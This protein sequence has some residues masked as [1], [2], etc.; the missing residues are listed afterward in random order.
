[1]QL[2]QVPGRLFEW[3]HENQLVED[4][5]GGAFGGVG[6]GGGPHIGRG[7]R[8]GGAAF[9]GGR[10]ALTTG[11]GGFSGTTHPL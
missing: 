4:V 8:G 1:M 6:Y 9:I 10:D 5:A 7:P 11:V 2:Y 3:S